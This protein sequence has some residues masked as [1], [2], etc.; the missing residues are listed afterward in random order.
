MSDII[1]FHAALIPTAARTTRRHGNF[2]EAEAAEV[3]DLKIRKLTLRNFV[4]RHLEAALENLEFAV[5]HVNFSNLL[6]IRISVT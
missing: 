1:E 2:R 4:L 3:R 5:K 6:Y